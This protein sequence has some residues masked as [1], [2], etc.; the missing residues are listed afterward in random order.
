MPRFRPVRRY[1]PRVAQGRGARGSTPESGDAANGAN[2]GDSRRD[3]TE[4]R[5]RR[6]RRRLAFVGAILLVLVAAGGAAAVI[7]KDD[8]ATSPR[9]QVAPGTT[10]TST[11]APAPTTT[12]QP[13]YTGWVD[14]ASAF[15][16]YY[17]SKVAGLLTFRGNPTRN[18]YGQ[19]PLPAAP[20][21]VWKY[22][23]KGMCSLSEDRGETTTWCGNGW[24][25]EPAVFERN[26]RTWVVFNGYDRAEHFV[27]AAT[28]QDI[29]PPFPTGDIIKGSVTVDPDGYP[30]VYFGSRD[31]YFRVVA[32]DR[33][34]ATELYKLSASAVS[35]VLWNDDWDGSGLVLNDYLF[36]GGENSQLHIVK[37]NRATGADGLVQVAPQLVFHAPGW[38]AQLL[39][40][41][42]DTEVSIENSVAIS[43]NTLYFANSGGLVQGWDIAGMINGTGT[44]PT[45]TFRFW[46]GDDTDASVVV[47]EAGMLYVGSE[48]ERHNASRGPGRADD[49]AEPGPARQPAGVVAERPGRH[50]RRACSRPPGSPATSR[51]TPPIRGGPWASTATPAQIRWEKHLPAPLMGSPVIVD[52]TWLQG[53]C[54]GVL[55]AY[56]VRNT[57]VDPPEIWQVPLGSCIEATPAVWKGRIYVGTRGGFEYALGDA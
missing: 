20:H 12:T 15:T 52:G 32:I 3:R 10:T 49:E 8:G 31:N 11:T 57:A 23:G 50:A 39:H 5:R 26:G 36:E 14:P 48:W 1:P 41:V 55:H 43:G 38:D 37:L 19:G 44:A 17:H 16:P 6:R 56:D 42:G 35:P 53:D 30:L 45:R 27:D 13:P 51:S 34:Q 47:D 2:G 7:T 4:R 24:T 54:A 22:P 29:L 9:A 40:D 28:G 46:T 21:V 25:G 18:Y 33:P